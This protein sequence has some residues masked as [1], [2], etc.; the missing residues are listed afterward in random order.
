[1]PFV[2]YHRAQAHKNKRIHMQGVNKEK[3]LIEIECDVIG[4]ITKTKEVIKA[5]VEGVQY[6]ITDIEGIT[7]KSVECIDAV[8]ITENK[9]DF[10]DDTAT[11]AL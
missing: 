3:Y 10:K 9:L 7:V 8:E 4:G 1:M 2:A 11:T 5:A 6:N